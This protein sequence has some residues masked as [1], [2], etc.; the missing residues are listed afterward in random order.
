VE[1]LRKV[2]DDLY[3][4]FACMPDAG[5]QKGDPRWDWWN[6]TAPERKRAREA[7]EGQAG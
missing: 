4:A 7:L 6:D 2:L 1:R 5:L 3:V